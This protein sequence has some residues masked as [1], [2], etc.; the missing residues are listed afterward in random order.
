MF[1]D[2]TSSRSGIEI[3]ETQGHAG[4]PELIALS[5]PLLDGAGR[6]LTPARACPVSNRPLPLQPTRPRRHADSHWFQSLA[7]H[8]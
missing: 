7:Q 2:L 5:R 3:D 1:T 4:L 8:G 6:G